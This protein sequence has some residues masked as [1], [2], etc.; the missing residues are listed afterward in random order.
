MDAFKKCQDSLGVTKNILVLLSC[1]M[2]NE[3]HNI[4]WD[5][6][7]T[8]DE[9]INNPLSPE[10]EALILS[11]RGM[12]RRM[13]SRMMHLGHDLSQEDLM[14][15][16]IFGAM[17]AAQKYKAESGYRF[18]TYAF[19]WARCEIERTI[20]WEGRSIRLPEW[21]RDTFH[22]IVTTELKAGRPLSSEELETKTGISKKNLETTRQLFQS[23]IE[24]LEKPHGKTD[25]GS[26]STLGSFLPDKS[27]ENAEE[28][29]IKRQNAREIHRRLQ[30]LKAVNPRAYQTIAM[31]FQLNGGPEMTLKEIGATMNVSRERARQLKIIGLRQLREWLEKEDF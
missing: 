4:D 9:K 31:H 15:A 5:P 21:R 23:P 1:G 18:N 11:A 29:V 27:T 2:N 17:R 25:G 10:Q 12:I 14:Q 30:Q 22:K 8:E 16:G 13:A 20:S 28:T 6:T 7:E 24:S 19:H 26:Q 3:A